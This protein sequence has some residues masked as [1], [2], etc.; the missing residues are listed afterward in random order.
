MKA[1]E[2][3]HKTIRRRILNDQYNRALMDL[4]G[5]YRD[6]LVVQS[7]SDAELIND[8]MR[9]AID[10]VADRGDA[11]SMLHRIDAITETLDNLL[12]NVVP[13]AAFESLLVTLRDPTLGT[14]HN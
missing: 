10:T 12:A 1:T 11:A 7:G 8:E 14:V 3:R 2:D 5:F 13:Q 4:T 9:N 6:V